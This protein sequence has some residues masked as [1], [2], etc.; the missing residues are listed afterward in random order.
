MRAAVFDRYGPPEVVR[1]EQ[2][3]APAPGRDEV[4][5]RV[6]AAAVT[7]GDAR[8]RAARFPRGL[9]VASRLA[10]GVTRPRRRILGSCCAGVVEAV[11]ERVRDLGPGEAVCA[12]TGARLGAHAERV[13]VAAKRV[14]RVPEGVGPVDAAGVLFGGT[15]AWHFLHDKAAVGAGASV[16]VNGA[17]GA[18]GTNAVQ[19]ART[20][21]ASV[22]GV[23]S[24]ANADLVRALGADHVI[25][26]TRVGLDTVS[27]RFDLVL[28]TVGNVPIAQGRRLLTPGG[29]LILVAAG[30]SGMLPGR[31]GVVAGPASERVEVIARLLELV[32]AGR[33]LVVHDLTVGLDDIVEA[34]RR[35]D[36]GHKVG[37]VVVTPR[38]VPGRPAP[39]PDS[40][41]TGIG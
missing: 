39:G 12:M 38:P 37:N 8:I 28:D 15:T 9:G 24:G 29:T 18:V 32:A 16:L 13:A 25:D 6:D 5:L 2:V 26:H 3:V 17:S 33:L 4:L 31:R 35:V 34:H 7:T 21:G 19:I 11:G 40:P 27:E 10:F 1:L 30:L 22:T 14:V 41:R 23:T 20:L 36:S